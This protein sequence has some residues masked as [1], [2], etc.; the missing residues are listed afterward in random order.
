MPAVT[1]DV[2]NRMEK[3]LQGGPIAI[4]ETH[5]SPHARNA[6]INLMDRRAVSHLS[7]ELPVGH[8]VHSRADGQFDARGNLVA[9]KARV[10]GY[11]YRVD[12]MH[13]PHVTLQDLAK[14]AM[15][16]RIPV[17]FHDMPHQVSRLRQL[18]TPATDYLTH[19]R[20]Y[21]RRLPRFADG[22]TNMLAERNQFT[23]AFL[24]ANLGKG[25]KV[26]F[27]LVVLAGDHH[28]QPTECGAGHTIQELL[29]ISQDRVFHC[30]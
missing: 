12:E 20:Q 6:I 14:Y 17:Y 4:G 29:G 8:P 7:I 22:L 9:R 10:Q 18:N 19:A 11:F 2:L 21:G 3:L 15:G 23:K 16:R 30:N 24:H 25:V 27:G 5:T 26:L 13:N 28:L 1:G